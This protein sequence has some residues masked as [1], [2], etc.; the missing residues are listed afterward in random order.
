MKNRKILIG[1]ATDALMI[2]LMAVMTFIPFVGFITIGPISFTIIHII[3]LIGAILFGRKR[4]L[5][6]GFVFGL[7]SFFKAMSYPGT[8]DFLF[9]NPFVSILPR[10]IFGLVSGFVFDFLKKKLSFR[11]FLMI[12]APVSGFLTIFHTTITITC[13][14]V[15][16]Y[17]DIF[18]ISQATGAKEI[19]AQLDGVF[20]NFANFILTIITIGS[21]C[22]ALAAFLFVPS[23]GGVIHKFLAKTSYNQYGLIKE[24]Q[25]KDYGIKK[26]ILLTAAVGLVSISFMV[27]GFMLYYVK[28]FN[29]YLY[30]IALI[31]LG[32]V[33]YIFNE[34][35][36]L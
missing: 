26:A 35:Y 8:V 21:A 23:I 7:F 12:S 10:A 15:F 9:V 30:G 25:E 2:A 19:L 18:F 29:N 14:Y 3:V 5:L 24:C 20:G 27:S 36:R 17:K 16:G 1:L 31:D 6:Y 28:D 11:E 22:E 33:V 32:V 13:L 4:G 34:V